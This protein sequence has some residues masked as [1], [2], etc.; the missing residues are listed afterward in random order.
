MAEQ[1][2][3]TNVVYQN[4]IRCANFKGLMLHQDCF[5]DSSILI[6][7][8]HIIAL[9]IALR[10]RLPPTASKAGINSGD[11]LFNGFFGVFAD[12]RQHTAN[13]GLHGSADAGAQLEN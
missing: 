3:S 4:Y 5:A 8:L 1:P 9:D 13:F 10:H 7:Y 2:V 11:G 6:K 12:H